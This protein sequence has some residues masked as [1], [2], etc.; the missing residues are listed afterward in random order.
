MKISGWWLIWSHEHNMWWKPNEWGYT[1]DVK[2]AGIY[3][4]A[5]AFHIVMKANLASQR[6]GGPNEAL[7][8]VECYA[9]VLDNNAL[10]EGE[11]D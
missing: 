8:P 7:V 3:S 1:E 9:D 2:E 5:Q 6:L 11:D 10:L 4:S